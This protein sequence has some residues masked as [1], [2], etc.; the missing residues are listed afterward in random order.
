MIYKG[1]V[2]Q[3]SAY[4]HSLGFPTANIPLTDDTSGIYAAK[5]R[6]DGT[7]HNAA[8]YA[9]TKRKLLEAHL[10]D[11]NE[12]LYGKEIAVELLERIRDDRQ[13]ANTE[14]AK[15]AIAE[16]V[17]AIRAYFNPA[18]SPKSGG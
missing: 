7:E 14:D 8:V 4:G 18:L 13:F 3:G 15:T 5:V 12:N 1:I 16:D 2:Q 10:L 11:F 6:C 17:R 9:D